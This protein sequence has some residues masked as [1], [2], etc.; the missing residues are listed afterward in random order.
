MDFFEE[1]DLA[2]RRTVQL[3]LLFAAAV[4][5]V[6]VAVYFL[7]MLFYTAGATDAAGVA[8]MTGDYDNVGQLALSFWDPGVLLFALC[9]TT[10]VVGL[11]SLYKIAQLRDG[12]SA[13]ALSLGGRKL[14][15]DATKLEERR[16]LNVVEE[17]AI[18]SGVP[19][20]DVYVLD[21]EPGI[22]AFAA[23]NTTSDAVIGVTQGTLQLLRR[24][25]LQGVV[26]HE[27]SHI[28]NGDSRINVRAIG[29]LHG[30]FLLA[31]IGR[32]LM[33]G[34]MHNRRKGGGGVALIGFG[35]LAIGSIG[36]FFGRM[37]QSSISRQRELLADAS[38]V[39][40]TR[41]T[42]GLVGALKKIGGAA[43]RSYLQTDEASHIFFSDAIRRL[44]LFAGI[45]RT[46]PPLGDR[47]RKL[48]PQWD[49]EFTEV[50]LPD[51]AD[52]MST[53]PDAPDGQ[54]NAFAEAPTEEAV[55]Q[56]IEHI[57]SP[58]PEQIAFARSLHAA[59]PD[60]WIHAVHQAPMAQAMIFGL[61]LARDEVL[62]GTELMR[63]AELTDPQTADLTLRF[64]SEA[65][66]RSSAEKIALFDMAMPTLRGLSVDEYE[67]FR[68]VIDALM[69]SDRRIDL[70]EYTLS[71]MIQRHLARHFEGTGPTPLRFRSLAALLPDARVLIATLARVG[72]RTEE[73]AERAF[74]H[75]A[76]ALQ[77]KGS[78]GAILPSGA[79]TLASV[80]QA[81]Q[82]YDAAAPA[83]KR[84]IMLACA[85]T[86]MADDEVTDHEAELIRA[87]GDALDCP[88]PPFVQSQ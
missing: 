32:F 68:A 2:R 36:V 73:E 30:I 67:R 10:T 58:R 82:R 60:L 5:G 9:S 20:P 27:F 23:G 12:G 80:E 41:D 19:V 46:H 56:A 59:L 34:S 22:N 77:L 86:V 40:F 39:Q 48:E 18:A 1:Q 14:D 7:A 69:Q 81:L 84:G 75:G 15:P 37:I 64:H 16:L 57:G 17:M 52:G 54:I 29:L 88:V 42:D 70:F 28:L 65:G 50:S 53:P 31:L 79:C 66:D 13:V 43:P 3:I 78:A 21:R 83:L 44:R 49:G 61:L 74:R 85:A 25:E 63:V 87:I 47:I 62:R 76:Q 51:I 33:R 72:S 11:G 55:S 38:A 71:R 24:D 45:F 8:Y 35:L 4:V 26:A 6:V